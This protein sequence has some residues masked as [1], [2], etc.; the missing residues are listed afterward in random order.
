MGCQ[1]FAPCEHGAETFT[2]AMP[3][4]TFGR[5]CLSEAGARAAAR[6][7]T[8]IALFTD[9]MLKDGPYVASVRQSLREANIDVEIFSEIRIE[10]DDTS[11]ENGARFISQGKFDGMVSVVAAR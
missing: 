7:M 4:L 5:G 3:K 6:G 1:Y 9:Q 8:R 10:A 2:I 11:V